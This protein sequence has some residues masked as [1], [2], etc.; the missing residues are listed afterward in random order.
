MPEY[1]NQ[2]VNERAN[3]GKL[4]TLELRR[5][6]SCSGA[7]FTPLSRR[8]DVRRSDLGLVDRRHPERLIDGT[9]ERRVGTGVGTEHSG[10]RVPLNL[11]LRLTRGVHRR[12]R[13]I[14]RGIHFQGKMEQKIECAGCIVRSLVRRE[15]C[16]VVAESEHAMLSAEPV[17]EVQRI[18]GSLEN[19]L[20]ERVPE[21]QV[22]NCVVRGVSRRDSTCES[23]AGNGRHSE[24]QVTQIATY[25]LECRSPQRGVSLPCLRDTE[26]L[27]LTRNPSK[28]STSR[29]SCLTSGL[30]HAGNSSHRRVRGLESC[31]RS[32]QRIPLTRGWRVPARQATRRGGRQ[33][34]ES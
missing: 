18:A 23:A 27:T 6:D 33:R 15:L 30:R 22:L 25:R 24:N 31:D 20:P 3:S 1:E 8:T 19:G 2:R 28:G 14:T 13:A 17:D 21:K 11:Q 16:R 29:R 9:R 4:D 7:R 32:R 12:Q 5:S 10:G 26:N 34:R